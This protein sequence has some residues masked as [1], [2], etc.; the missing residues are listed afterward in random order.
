M[1]SHSNK[2]FDFIIVFKLTIVDEGEFKKWED[3]EVLYKENN[4]DFITREEAINELKNSK[5]NKDKDFNDE[6]IVNELLINEGYYTT[7][8]FWENSELEYFE[9][10]YTSKS[11]DKIVVFGR[12][13]YEG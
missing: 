6:D 11:G 4:E 12:H 2:L 8:Q 3:G 1:K 7:E 9:E 5:W 13:G 10:K